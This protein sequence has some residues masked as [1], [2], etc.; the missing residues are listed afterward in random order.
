[1]SPLLTAELVS[2]IYDA[3][4]DPSVWPHFLGRLC[5]ALHAAYGIFFFRDANESSVDV[6]DSA[7]F[8]PAMLADYTS[9]WHREDIYLAHARNFRSGSVLISS[10]LVP[11]EQ[12]DRTA[13]VKEFMAPGGS[14]EFVGSV[15]AGADSAGTRAFLS[16]HRSSRQE[17]FG[18]KAISLAAELTPHLQRACVLHREL[19]LAR[20]HQTLALEALNLLS[21]G[22]VLYLHSER[23]LL[24]N[25]AA[26]E[27]IRDDDGI[28]WTTGSSITLH[29][30]DANETLQAIVRRTLAGNRAGEGGRVVVPR[31]SG[32]RPYVIVVVPIAPSRADL[33]ARAAACVVITDP[34]RRVEVDPCVL[35]DAFHLS[36]AEVKLARL[37]VDGHS[38]DEASEML[39]VTRNTVR[40][41]LKKIFEK[42]ATRKQAELMRLI[43]SL[44]AD[45]PEREI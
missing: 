33:F 10:R 12:A 1:M 35:S 29:D 28:S 32:K 38:L 9:Y 15:V 45:Q 7:R 44:S 4:V 24:M 6:I 42:T 26:E 31:R 11:A 21:S 18:K 41:H 30:D 27:M 34:E 23:I 39:N 19:A 25:K 13:F 36:R 43:V 17:A 40:S 14:K 2:T 37:L 8:D 3:A 22:I 5:D 16:V 20:W